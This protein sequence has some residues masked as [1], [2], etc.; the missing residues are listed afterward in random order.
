MNKKKIHQE[1]IQN[2]F[3][4][5]SLEPIKKSIV[6]KATERLWFTNKMISMLKEF[7]LWNAKNFLLLHDLWTLHIIEVRDYYF[8]NDFNLALC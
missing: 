3:G 2:A 5:E 7:E 8:H 4:C 1:I 6:K